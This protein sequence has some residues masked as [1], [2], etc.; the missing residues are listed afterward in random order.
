MLMTVFYSSVFRFLVEF[1][2]I[3][4]QIGILGVYVV[5]ISANLKQVIETTLKLLFETA[6]RAHKKYCI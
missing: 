6:F 1:F 2:L 4:Y 5:F 3:F